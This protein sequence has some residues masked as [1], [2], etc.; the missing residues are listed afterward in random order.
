VFDVWV[1]GVGVER[2]PQ[3][4]RADLRGIAIDGVGAR[5]RAIHQVEFDAQNNR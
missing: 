1:I 2:Q 3:A 5:K 4:A